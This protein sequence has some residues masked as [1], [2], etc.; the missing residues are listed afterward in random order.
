[1]AARV[2]QGKPRVVAA[3]SP[4]PGG[5]ANVVN[6]AVTSAPYFNGHV[7]A[8]LSVGPFGEKFDTDTQTIADA[9]LAAELNTALNA[10]IAAI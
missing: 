2:V 4:G 9:E 3:A 1:M 8:S 7:V 5:G 6:L 10:L